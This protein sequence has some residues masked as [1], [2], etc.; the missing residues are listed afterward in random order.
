MMQSVMRECRNFFETAYADGSFSISAAGVLS[1]MTALGAGYIAI[2]GSTFHNGVHCAL[3][4][5]KLI[6]LDETPAENFSGRVWLLCPP[7]DFVRLC[8]EIDDYVS[9]NPATAFVSE[10]FGGWSGTRA[11]GQNGVLSWQQVFAARLAPFRRMY[12]EV[13]A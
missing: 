5:G 13:R 2:E 10:S 11:S 4:S 7:A 12:T 3:N 6:D 9:K 8:E 1:P